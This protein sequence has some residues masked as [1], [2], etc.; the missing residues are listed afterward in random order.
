M[1]K[2]KPG[3]PLAGL[4]VVEIAGIGPAPYACML[5]AELGA[6]VLRLDRP[7]GAGPLATPTAGLNRSRPCAAVDLKQPGAAEV[8]MELLERADVLVEGMRPGVMERLGLGPGVCL[9]RNPRLIYGRMTGWGQSGPR[10]QQVGHD[11]TYAA[12]TGA[13]HSVGPAEQP[14]PAVN[15]VADFGGGAMFLL[16]GILSAVHAR[17]RTGVGQVIDAAMVDGATS[18]LTMVYT[19]LGDGYW[20]DARAANLLDGGCP[21][22]RTYRCADGGFVAVGALEPAFYADLVRGLGLAGHE[23]SGGSRA[24]HSA[25]NSAGSIMDA[26][27]DRAA[28]PELERLFAD[29]FATR[30]VADWEDTFAGTTACVAPVRSLTQAMADPHLAARGVFTSVGGV[31]QPRAAPRFSA[32]PELDPTPPRK[33]GQDTIEAF[34]AWGF[35]HERIDELL[36]SG[37][38]VQL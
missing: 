2:D 31:V 23:L 5:L 3:G 20:A 32:T 7:G 18:L 30:T 17:A 19:M 24:R 35:S 1:T 34:G 38:L 9:A 11:I 15:L 4:R 25:A 8:V 21:F 33:S 10:A 26:Q 36:A 12:L 27:H 6:D 37:V 14:V 28:W 16:V 13:L 22:Y 29:V